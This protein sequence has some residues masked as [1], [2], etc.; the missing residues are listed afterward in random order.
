VAPGSYDV[1]VQDSNGVRSN[2]VTIRFDP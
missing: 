1:Y 2:R